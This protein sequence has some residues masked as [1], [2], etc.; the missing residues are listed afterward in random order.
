M[1]N[2]KKSILNANILLERRYLLEAETGES[3][4]PD[5]DA[6]GKTWS[7]GK[8]NTADGKFKLYIKNKGE[9]KLKNPTDFKNEDASY[10]SKISVYQQYFGEFNTEND[11][12]AAKDYIVNQIKPSEQQTESGTA[13]TA[14]TAGTVGIGGT[15]GVKL[16]P[17][18]VSPV[19]RA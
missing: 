5:T 11:A 14:G 13:G 10:W 18:E 7:V 2:K 17:G 16:K 6:Y 1:S 15:S 9:N 8:S 12:I 19:T 3:N 4:L